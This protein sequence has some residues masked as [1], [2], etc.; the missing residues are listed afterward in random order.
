MDFIRN[1]IVVPCDLP[2]SLDRLD[3]DI[4][5]YLGKAG[6]IRDQPID[7]LG[8]M[9]PLSIELYR[10]YKVDV[11]RDPLEFAINNQHMNCGISVDILGRSNLAGLRA[12]G[13]AAGMHG[14]ARP[15]G[16]VLNAGQVLG[17][18]VAEHIA[19]SVTA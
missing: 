3:S 9:N 16:A 11:T 1:P 18:R 17:T 12:I 5:A 8:H 10:R 15:G 14:V 2:L 6:A 13:Y 4:S 7:R 19:A